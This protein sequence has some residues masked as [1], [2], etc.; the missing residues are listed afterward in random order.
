MTPRVE[1]GQT[2]MGRKH[3]VRGGVGGVGAGGVG[4]RRKRFDL[5][6]GWELLLGWERNEI[7]VAVVII[8]RETGWNLGRGRHEA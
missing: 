1:K 4:W 3:S 6:W 7:E 8:N 2:Q 5:R